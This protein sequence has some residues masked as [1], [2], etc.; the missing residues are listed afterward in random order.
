MKRH[1]S[2]IANAM[3]CNFTLLNLKPLV[4]LDS[5]FPKNMV[6]TAQFLGLIT[7]KDIHGT[8]NETQTA[9]S[10]RTTPQDPNQP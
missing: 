10:W 8:W 1:A 4:A 7:C 3:Q 2:S 6:E 9:A 5:N